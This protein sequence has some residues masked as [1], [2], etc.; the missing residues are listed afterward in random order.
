MPEYTSQDAEYARFVINRLLSAERGPLDIPNELAIGDLEGD[1][2]DFLDDLEVLKAFGEYAPVMR[3]VNEPIPVSLALISEI[4]W[5]RIPWA[6]KWWHSMF[7]YEAVRQLFRALE[8]R[9]I[10]GI[11][12]LP[13][14]EVLWIFENRASD[15]LATRMAG[16]R[17]MRNQEAEFNSTKP[18]FLNLFQRLGGSKTTTPGCQFTVTTNSSGLRVFWSGAYRLSPNYFNH[19]TTPTRSVLQSGTFVFG[20]DG[21]AYGNLIHWD[22]NA[23]VTLPGYPTVHLNY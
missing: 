4:N 17:E 6:R 20:V 8:K 22:Q 18:I 14:S 3:F 16:I 21:G 10:E 19:P 5:S 7:G 13:I 11:E 12:V 1:T 23:V 15:F 2:L 9:H